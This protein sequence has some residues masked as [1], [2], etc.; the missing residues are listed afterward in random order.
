ML[1]M[2]CPIILV[3]P[4]T[5]SGHA[6]NCSWQNNPQQTCLQLLHAT[7]SMQCHRS[8]HA[9]PCTLK[10]CIVVTSNFILH[11]VVPVVAVDVLNIGPAHK[12]TIQHI[13]VGTRV[14]HTDKTELR[15]EC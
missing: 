12:S 15:F 6:A 9:K 11:K 13:G 14:L 3:R 8:M 7:A 4:L 2:H 1:V 5:T 10:S